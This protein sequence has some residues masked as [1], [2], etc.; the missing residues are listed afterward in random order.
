MKN[1]SN[2]LCPHCGEPATVEEARG[3]VLP[4]GTHYCS[5]CQ[6]PFNLHQAVVRIAADCVRFTDESTRTENVI[7]NV[8]HHVSSVPP[9]DFLTQASDRDP[10]ITHL[11]TTVTTD[12]MAEL[13]LHK[14]HRS[15]FY[16]HYE[17]VLDV[18]TSVST[19]LLED[20]NDW[21]DV[22]CEVLDG[23]YDVAPYVN[24]Y[25]GIGQVSILTRSD[26]IILIGA[27]RVRNPKF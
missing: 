3:L 11:G 16:Y 14:P 20:D 8:W 4:V 1:E 15:K 6:E 22:E 18:Q 19:E 10:I 24:R 13:T 5:S 21:D 7:G 26:K 9:A 25:E 2:L 23:V 27:S 17:F 12:A